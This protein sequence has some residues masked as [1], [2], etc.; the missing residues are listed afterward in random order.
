MESSKFP[1]IK[2]VDPVKVLKAVGHVAYK[3]FSQ[4]GATDQPNRGASEC[5]NEGLYGTQ[6]TPTIS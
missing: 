1:E 5:L 2:I 4:F 3:L 6:H